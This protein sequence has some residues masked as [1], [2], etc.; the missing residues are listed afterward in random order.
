ME[1]ILTYVVL[2]AV[3][4]RLVSAARLA[5]SGAGRVTVRKVF[6]RLR[7]R[8]LWPIPIVLGAVASLASLLWEVPGLSWGW[9]TAI[10]GEGNPVTG[11]TDH[12]TGTVW[13]WV[14]PLVFL[15]LVAPALPLFALAEER[16]FRRGAQDW[17]PARRLGKVV[18]F[19][20]IHAVIG[21]PIAVALALSLGGVYFMSVYLRWYRLTA[22]QQDAVLESTVAHTAYNA[23][24]FSV[25][26]VVIVLSA[27]GAL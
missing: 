21:I 18:A 15:L 11:T 17:T 23:V 1:T 19:G 27:A 10:G 6:G 12:T 4:I 2:G 8:H 3:G 13:E 14:I 26:L 9:W 25:A 20:L 5:V 7:W 16:M 22:D 24:I